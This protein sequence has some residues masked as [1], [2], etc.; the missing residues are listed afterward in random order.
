MQIF[1]ISRSGMDVEWRR[2]EVIAQ[3]IANAG[4]SQDSKGATYQPLTLV[5][6]PRRATGFESTMAGLAN[7]S[8]TL[9]GAQVYG[10]QA[11]NSVPR[12]IFEPAHP[13]ADAQG[14]VSYPSIDHVAEMT[15]MVKTT[16]IY[17]AN[18][19]AFNSI[20]G[21]YLKALELGNRS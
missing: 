16:R 1:E 3:N 21:M 20:R 5:S 12:K 7:P 6:G 2:M 8:S 9:A 19:L 15:L 4:S 11:Q 10:V 18:V 17:E 14:F 13:N